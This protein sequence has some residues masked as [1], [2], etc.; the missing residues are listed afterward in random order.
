MCGG[1][2]PLFAS[3]KGR[4]KMGL[5]MGLGLVLLATS[6]PHHLLIFVFSPSS[7]C[8]ASILWVQNVREVSA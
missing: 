2:Y 5:R 4:R 8:A 6:P 1:T 3:A 7:G